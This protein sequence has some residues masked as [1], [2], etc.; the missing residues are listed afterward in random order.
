MDAWDSVHCWFDLDDN[1]SVKRLLLLS[2]LLVMDA[3]SML[4]LLRPIETSF[5][6]DVE[7]DHLL[8]SGFI[9]HYMV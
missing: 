2:F 5:C 7:G 6:R 9:A 1:V 4:S 3:L 8:A